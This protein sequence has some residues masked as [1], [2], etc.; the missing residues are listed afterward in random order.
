L[1][2]LSSCLFLVARHKVGQED[3][4]V[5]PAAATAVESGEMPV[6][7]PPP[8]LHKELR[9]PELKDNVIIVGDI[10]GCLDEFKALL[11]KCNY[12]A[13]LHSVVLVGD[14]VNKGPFSAEVVKF[15]RQIGAHSVRGNHDE[16][17]L[18]ARCRRTDGCTVGCSTPGVS[19][20]YQYTLQWT[21]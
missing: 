19:A 10:H 15:C 13:R 6:L 8:C 20:K 3:Q 17:A 4:S 12:D 21:P 11:V 16:A 9:K 18:R 5:V 7:R 14:L 2:C 1:F